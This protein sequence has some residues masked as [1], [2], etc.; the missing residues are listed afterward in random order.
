MRANEIYTRN[1]GDYYEE[2]FREPATL[3]P[4]GEISAQLP[5]GTT[6]YFINLIDSNNFLVSYPKVAPAPGQKYSTVALPTDLNDS[7][8][9]RMPAKDV[10]S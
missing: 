1:G 3:L 7:S 6:H 10:L 8:R 2:W 4:G 9:E 5:A